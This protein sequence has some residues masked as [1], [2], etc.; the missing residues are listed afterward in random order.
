[1]LPILSGGWVDVKFMGEV[2]RRER[3]EVIVVA[4][5]GVYR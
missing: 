4:M 2:S 3:R 5:V 1:M